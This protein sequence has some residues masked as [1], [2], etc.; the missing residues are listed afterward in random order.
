ML[1]NSVRKQQQPGQDL[2]GSTFATPLKRLNSANKAVSKSTTAKTK[3]QP[4]R[5]LSS[6][7]NSVTSAVSFVFQAILSP[8]LVRNTKRD[9]DDDCSHKN[10]SSVY[11]D[12]EN[13]NASTGDIHA[14][15]GLDDIPCDKSGSISSTTTTTT[16]IFS[17]CGTTRIRHFCHRIPPQYKY[18]CFLCWMVYKLGTAFVVLWL[19]HQGVA[20]SNPSSSSSLLSSSFATTAENNNNNNVTKILYIVTSLAEYNNGRRNTV[21]GQDRLGEVVLPILVDSVNSMVDNNNSK[22]NYQVDV[23]LILAYSMRP[24]R[25]RLIRSALPSAVGLQIWNEACPMGYD[26]NRGT[27]QTVVADNTRAL[28]RQHR[29]VI[30]DKLP[31][32][33]LFVAF[34]DDMRITGTHVEHYLEVS[35]GLEQ[36]KRDWKHVSNM[37]E[38]YQ[39]NTN[40]SFFGAL[41]SRQLDRLIPGFVRVEVLLNETEYGAQIEL[42]P[43]PMDYNVVGSGRSLEAHFDP[44]PCCHVQMTPRG[45]TPAHPLASNVVV[46]E[47][48]VKALGVRELLSNDESSNGQKPFLDWVTLLPGPGKRLLPKDGI[49]NFWSGRISNG[50]WD[51]RPSPGQPELIAQ[52]GGW[53]A[54][55]AQI[56]RWNQQGDAEEDHPQ[57]CQGTFLPPFGEPVYRKDGQESM[58]VEL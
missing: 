54:T 57:L 1:T 13:G 33:D 43:I 58:N 37:K 36:L 53:M 49:A 38:P 15:A 30:K 23:Y 24:E 52:Q 14:V 41:T 20:S 51:V 6:P 32:Y 9:E 35:D 11:C 18:A 7:N 5:S 42:D 47:T 48:N 12:Y 34:E 4:L 56:L 44:I 25:E 27:G 40:A 3:Q 8:T 21:A 39:P 2:D 55:K 17:Y 10:Y 29:Y 19:V 50:A 31:Y 16:P 22:L 28:A 45:E 46:W 26:L